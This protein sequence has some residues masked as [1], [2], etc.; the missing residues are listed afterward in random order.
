MNKN[1]KKIIAT[2]MISSMLL[3]VDV[4]AMGVGE[5]Q[6]SES[7]T[8]P[9]TSNMVSYEYNNANYTDFLNDM[10]G[11]VYESSDSYV[12]SY[13]TPVVTPEQD[14]F[15]MEVET[16]SMVDD[17]EEDIQ[18]GVI[19]NTDNL[20]NEDKSVISYFT[21][22]K[23][24][25]KEF[26]QSDDFTN[27]K[28]KAKEIVVKGIDFLFYDGD[29]NGITR[30]KLT[31]EGKKEVIASIEATVEFLDEYF[32]GFSDSFGNKYTAAKLY[33]SQKFVNVLD[34]VKEWIGEDNYS[35]LGEEFSS[36][37]EDFGDVFGILGDVL[38]EHYQSW[39]LK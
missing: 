34:K 18:E 16:E 36:I 33:L 22:A 27:I 37:G 4:Q 6:Y 8:Y 24:K 12:P 38:D 7:S 19:D 35:S 3:T 32:P 28:I 29:I 23:E 25:L 9:V 39:K 11:D 14:V 1:V 2:G 17:I 21:D 15:P 10:F 5:V 31:E 26:A 20:S 13:S 30:E